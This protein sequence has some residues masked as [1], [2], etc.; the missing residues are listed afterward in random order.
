MVKLE[1]PVFNISV[2]QMFKFC[3]FAILSVQTEGIKLNNADLS[4]AGADDNVQE[5][6][7]ASKVAAEKEID[8]YTKAA[9]LKQPK[10]LEIAHGTLRAAT[11]SLKRSNCVAGEY[12][13]DDKEVCS[14]C[15]VGQYSLAMAT[16]CMRCPEKVSA[17]R[18]FEKECSAQCGPSS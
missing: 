17:C 9:L 5:W 18:I 8:A 11:D 6:L 13:E 12:Y 1:S 3:K 14:K 16:V 10:E 7:D 2:F 4:T 15:P